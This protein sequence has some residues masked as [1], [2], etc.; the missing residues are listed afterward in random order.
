[1]NEFAMESI[2]LGLILPIF[3][4]Q[5]ILIVVAVFDWIK[6]EENVRGNRWVWLVII[7][8]LTMIGP[9]LYFIFGRRK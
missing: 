1:M 2:N 8:V 7:L 5:G 4:I 3:F 6:Q 9:I